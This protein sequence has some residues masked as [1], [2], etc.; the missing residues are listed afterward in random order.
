AVQLCD[1]LAPTGA[2]FVH[3][4][5]RVSGYLRVMLDELIGL[6]QFRNEVTW[7]RRV[8]MSSAVHESNRLGVCT[9]VILYYAK[10]TDAPFHPQYNKDSQEYQEYIR[11]RFTMADPDGR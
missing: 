6:D 9:D 8:G 4:D 5:F 1:L 3:C 10:S 7:K 11:T 2:L